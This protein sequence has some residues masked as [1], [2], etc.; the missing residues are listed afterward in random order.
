LPQ[1]FIRFTISQFVIILKTI[2][3]YIIHYICKFKTK[4]FLGVFEFTVIGYNGN[5]KNEKLMENRLL[6][7]QQ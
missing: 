1:L 2:K 7:I 3:K 6:V 4:V 5:M